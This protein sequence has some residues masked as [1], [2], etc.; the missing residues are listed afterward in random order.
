MKKAANN[1]LCLITTTLSMLIY[2]PPILWIMKIKKDIHRTW[3]HNKRLKIQ[4]QRYKEEE[5]RLKNVDET[6]KTLDKALKD[7]DNLKET[8]QFRDKTITELWGTAMIGT[9]SLRNYIHQNREKWRVYAKPTN[10][11]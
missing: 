2:R 5:A 7:I 11:S 4:K 1:H 8:M 10:N 3:E 9:G 6:I